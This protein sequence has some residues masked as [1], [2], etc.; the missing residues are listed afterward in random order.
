MTVDKPEPWFK[1][2]E[3]N[4]VSLSI[5]EIFLNETG[6][7]PSRNKSQMLY[8]EGETLGDNLLSFHYNGK[9]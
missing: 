5:E 2:V 3:G 1:A 4:V 6:L 8:G 9:W 7:I